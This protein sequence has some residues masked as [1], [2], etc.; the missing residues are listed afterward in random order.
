M[1]GLDRL[2]YQSRWAH[3]AP[4]RKFLLWLAMMMLA[5]VLPPVGQ[6]IE[7]LII[8]GLSCWLLRISLWRWCRWMAIPFGFLLVGVDNDS[9]QHQ[10]RA[11]NAA[12]WH[13]CRAVLDRDYPCGRGLRRMKRSGVA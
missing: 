7:L 6:G 13:I 1:T 3:V 5:F 12:G 2:S 11:A 4:Q 10:P 9:L 8:A